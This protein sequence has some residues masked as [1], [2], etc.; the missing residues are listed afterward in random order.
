M[1]QKRASKT[2]SLAGSFISIEQHSFMADI[3]RTSSGKKPRALCRHSIQGGS[4]EGYEK[5]LFHSG[6]WRRASTDPDPAHHKQRSQSQLFRRRYFERFSPTDSH[7]VEY[8]HTIPTAE[9]IHWVMT[10]G[11][12]RI[13]CSENTPFGQ[14]QSA[15]EAH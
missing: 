4:Y 15:G 13:E 5:R 3:S 11:Q 12:L 7:W 2:I 6:T 10:H 9:F 14:V 8:I 1:N